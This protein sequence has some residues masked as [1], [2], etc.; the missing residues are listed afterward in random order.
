MTMWPS[1]IACRISACAAAL[2][3]CS[4]VRALGPGGAGGVG[5]A[6][7]GRVWLWPALLWKKHAGVACVLLVPLEQQPFAVHLVPAAPSPELT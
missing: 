7:G 2:G 3:Q 5:G 1:L 6:A 4:A